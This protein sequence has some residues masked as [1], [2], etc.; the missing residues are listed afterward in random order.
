MIGAM[1]RHPGRE[2]RADFRHLR[3][4]QFGLI[5]FHAHKLPEVALRALHSQ[6]R[7]MVQ[8]PGFKRER[9]QPIALQRIAGA[10][11][12]TGGDCGFARIGSRGSRLSTRGENSA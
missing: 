7:E 5:E 6:L 8:R 4:I 12:L 1:G 3:R 2:L 9:S 10:W 11:S